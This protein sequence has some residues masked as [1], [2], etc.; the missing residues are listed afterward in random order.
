MKRISIIALL[1]VGIMVLALQSEAKYVRYRDGTRALTGLKGQPTQEEWKLS[2]E[3][4]TVGGGGTANSPAAVQ[5]FLDYFDFSAL[6][7]NLAVGDLIFNRDAQQ[8]LTSIMS[9]TNIYVS[10]S[11]DAS[12][13]LSRITDNTNQ[14]AMN[15]NTSGPALG[16]INRLVSTA[17]WTGYD[18]Y[19]F[20]YSAAGIRRNNTSYPPV[21]QQRTYDANGNLTSIAFNT[22]TAGVQRGNAER[23]W[24]TYRTETFDPATG[25]VIANNYSVDPQPANWEP[26]I[27]GKIVEDKYGNR[28]V[29]VSQMVINGTTYSPGQTVTATQTSGGQV[30]TTSVTIKTHYLISARNKSGVTI[31]NNNI[32]VGAQISLTGYIS[33]V[34]YNDY[35]YGKGWW[36]VHEGVR[37]EG[38]EAA[39]FEFAQIS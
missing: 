29:E 24:Y 33:D 8:R 6:G 9:G 7:L 16:K 23:G 10:L 20:D 12:G 31:I 36:N 14:I 17:Q 3:L 5:S 28:F 35:V 18:A 26:T 34:T 13:N 4:N 2:D 11:Y 19:Y 27:V 39:I 38:Q 37:Y 22:W 25:N 32:Q 21:L 15:Y 30:G 1:I